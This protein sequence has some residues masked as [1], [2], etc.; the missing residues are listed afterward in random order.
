MSRALIRLVI[1]M[2]TAAGAMYL[3]DPDS[4]AA[5]RHVLRRRITAAAKDV[6][7][8]TRVAG[9]SFSARA[10]RLAR[11]TRSLFVL[12]PASDEALAR[13][14][15]NAVRHTA[16][17]PQEIGVSVREGHVLMH[18]EVSLEEHQRILEAVRSQDGVI[19][20]RDCL[21]QRAETT[22]DSDADSG[23]RRFD[24]RQENW[25]AALRLT[26]GTLGALMLASGV[27]QRTV[28]AVLGGVIGA[29][30]VLRSVS[31]VPFKRFSPGRG[32][33]DVR[34]S[35]DV[36]AP[37]SHVFRLLALPES[38]PAFTPHVREVRRNADGSSHWTVGG[39][40]GPSL[41]WDSL[42]TV[43]RPNEMLGW[44]SAPDSP[45]EHAGVIHFEALG[46]DQTRLHIELSYSPP[47]GVVGHGLARLLGV[48][49]EAELEDSLGH[50][51][52]IQV[53]RHLAETGELPKSH[54][55]IA[56]VS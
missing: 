35:V 9:S 19:V 56:V 48:D 24:P 26:S 27:R 50:G 52:F 37:V 6:N 47:G 43:H 25:P 46:A 36:L 23:L 55:A 13:R 8:R 12:D 45:I 32:V 20:V 5:R 33:I 34:K 51:Q 7:E 16:S 54:A 41:E 21:T 49:P 1:G 22:A 39:V 11:R 38:F 3:L 31:N 28:P 40:R 18:G 44:R 42:T 2:A 53:A 4:G 29:A 17:R 14:V 15:R 30:M 10:Q